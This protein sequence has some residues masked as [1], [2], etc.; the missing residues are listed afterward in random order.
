MSSLK[1]ALLGAPQI[2]LDGKP[3]I[4]Q[5]SK[6]LALLAYLAVSGEPQRRDTLATLL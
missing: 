2:E 3:I 4:I 6:V 5:R 1:I